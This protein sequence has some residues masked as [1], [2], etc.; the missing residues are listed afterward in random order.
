[1]NNE[2]VLEGKTNEGTAEKWIFSQIMPQSFKWHSE[3]THDNGK[4]WLLTEEMQ[5]RK[6]GAEQ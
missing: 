4:T 3:E 2:I 5:I 1:M 6:T